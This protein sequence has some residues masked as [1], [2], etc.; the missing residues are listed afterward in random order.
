MKKI[1]FVLTLIFISSCSEYIENDRVLAQKICENEKQTLKCTEGC[2][3]TGRKLSKFTFKEDTVIYIST[4]ENGEKNVNRSRDCLIVDKNNW[5]CKYNR[6]FDGVFNYGYL[7]K[8][9][10]VCAK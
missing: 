6:M 4:Q 7:T 3:P 2:K 5:Q 9:L 8:G 10:R 1:V